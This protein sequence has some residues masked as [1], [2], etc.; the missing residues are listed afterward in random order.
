LQKRKLD[1]INRIDRIKENAKISTG[2]TALKEC[3]G[4]D[5][6]N[7]TEKIKI[8]LILSKVFSFTFNPVNPVIPV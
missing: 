7:R 3:T 2:L 4:F 1:R 8:L 5:R 6:V